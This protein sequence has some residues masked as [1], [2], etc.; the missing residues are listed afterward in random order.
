MTSPFYLGSIT[1]LRTATT[2][3]RTSS[4]ARTPKGY[5]LDQIIADQIGGQSRLPS[6]QITA[7]SGEGS[8]A[9]NF[10]KGGAVLPM[11]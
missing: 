10:T 4:A 1:G 6:I 11:V 5:S 9:M 3:G 7:G 8:K 2:T